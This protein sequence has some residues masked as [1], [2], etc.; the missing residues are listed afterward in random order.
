MA[1]GEAKSVYGPLDAD[2][3][4]KRGGYAPGNYSCK[5][6]TCSRIFT[7]DKLATH[8]ANC[9]YT[10][11]DPTHRHVKTGGLYM[12][13]HMKATIEA[14]MTPAVVYEAM[15]GTLWVRPATEFWDGRFAPIDK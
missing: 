13:R 15:D 6:T 5:C 3:R 14:T 10:D 9:E 8:C 7:G 1:D 4:P 2:G 12:L 11:W